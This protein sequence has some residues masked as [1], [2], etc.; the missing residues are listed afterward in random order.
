MKPIKEAIVSENSTA[1]AFVSEV[2]WVVGTVAVSYIAITAGRKA[3]KL[4]KT[5]VSSKLSKAKP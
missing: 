4:G 3:Y 5:L 2:I 1:G